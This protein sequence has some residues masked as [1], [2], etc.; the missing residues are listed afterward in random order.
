MDA[1]TVRYP[2]TSKD[3]AGLKHDELKDSFLSRP[4][5]F[6]REWNGIFQPDNVSF[7]SAPIR[8]RVCPHHPSAATIS[9]LK[10][11]DTELFEVT[12]CHSLLLC[13]Y[14]DS[15]GRLHRPVGTTQWH[16]TVSRGSSVAQFVSASFCFIHQR[17]VFN[18]CP[19]KG[20]MPFR[21]WAISDSAGDPSEAINPRA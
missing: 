12:G 6:F 8:C 11:K 7:H 16:W 2:H 1:L 10:L 20:W 13:G 4:V 5:L 17:Y 15:S 14:D 21:W 18:S 3:I 9:C 19:A